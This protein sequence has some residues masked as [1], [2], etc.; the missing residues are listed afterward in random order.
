MVLFVPPGHG[1]DP[2]RSPEYYDDTFA[3]LRGVGIPALT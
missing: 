3:Y 2:T 1:R